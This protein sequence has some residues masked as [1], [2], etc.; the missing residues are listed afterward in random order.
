MVS[1]S[2]DSIPIEE[3]PMSWINTIPYEK[4]SGYLKSLYDRIKDPNDNVDNIMTAHSLR[5]HS[6]EAHLRLYK[7]VLHHRDNRLAKWYL[8]TIGL[9]VSLINKCF[10][11]AQHHFEGII[12]LLNNKEQCNALKTSLQKETPQTFFE[13]KDLAGLHYA[14]K[15]TMTPSAMTE[16]D[17]KDLRLSGFNDGEILEIN[18]VTAYFSY[19]NRTA[20][21][22]GINTDGDTLGLSPSSDDPDDLSHN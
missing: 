7:N 19:A 13:G 1:L 9:Y 17:I 18:Q 11:C 4:S 12:R 15:L 5:P 14:Y 16:Q 10:Y 20:L 21:G 2:A 6:L 22:L 3:G 8:E